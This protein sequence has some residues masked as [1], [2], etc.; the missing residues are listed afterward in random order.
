M[1]PQ[2]LDELE[3]AGYSYTGTAKECS[4]GTQILW[5]ITPA[6]KW[7]PFS[8][9]KDSRLVPHHAVCERVKEFRAADAKLRARTERPKPKQLDM[10]GGKS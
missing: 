6:R 4:C 1:Q 8:A 5:F 3:A 7:M 2:T 9:L 10:F